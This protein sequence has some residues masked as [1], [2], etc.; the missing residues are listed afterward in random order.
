M[1]E[2]SEKARSC[3]TIGVRL[4]RFEPLTRGLGERAGVLHRIAEPCE[5]GLRKRFSPLRFAVDCSALRPWCQNGVNRYR[6]RYA[7]TRL[8][9]PSIWANVANLSSNVLAALRHVL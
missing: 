5:S 7:R 8:I 1:G 4:E 6:L 3:G 9:A 2:V